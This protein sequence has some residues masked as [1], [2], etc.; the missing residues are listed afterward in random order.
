MFIA[1]LLN[2]D[3]EV[4]NTFTHYNQE[5]LKK[6]IYKKFIRYGKIHQCQRSIVPVKFIIEDSNDN[7]I[8][9]GILM[10]DPFARENF[11]KQMAVSYFDR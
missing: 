6:I 2:Y 10:R 7:E 3:G 5:T 9:R 4:T 11:K 1:K 8:Y